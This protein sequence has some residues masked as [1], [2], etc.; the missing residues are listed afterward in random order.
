MPVTAPTSKRSIVVFPYRTAASGDQP[1]LPACRAWRILA[2][3][4]LD[5]D[6]ANPAVA[7]GVVTVNKEHPRDGVYP[8]WVRLTDAGGTKLPP[9][10]VHDDGWNLAPTGEKW[11]IEYVGAIGGA[12]DR[13]A[14]VVEVVQDVGECGQ[15][16]ERVAPRNRLVASAAS[17]G[18]AICST[19]IIDVGDF[20]SLY[21]WALSDGG[22]A[23]ARDLE[24]VY[25]GDDAWTPV[26]S[27]LLPA[28]T[29]AP[30]SR[31]LALGHGAVASAAPLVVDALPL[32]FPRY[33]LIKLPAAGLGSAI[34]FV[35]A[36][37]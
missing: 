23:V 26:N 22:G 1:K 29:P 27:E 32:A 35:T 17:A 25:Y 10:L 12:L 2:R 16:N 34:L 37:V 20:R 28:W 30:G 8:V 19:G 24:I 31:R 15:A 3:R 4:A 6:A 36:G 21:V 18:G 13:F 11:S 7:A 9:I 14:Y 33:V 5:F